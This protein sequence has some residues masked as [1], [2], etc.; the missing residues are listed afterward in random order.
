M[1]D[2]EFWF[3]QHYRPNAR[4]FYMYS[5]S[6]SFLEPAISRSVSKFSFESKAIVGYS[7]KLP[8]LNYIP[9]FKL[10]EL[11]RTKVK[12]SKILL[13]S[14]CCLIY[15]ESIILKIQKYRI[16]LN[17]NDL[18]TKGRNTDRA[19]IAP[20]QNIICPINLCSKQT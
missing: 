16:F 14:V 12:N 2:E 10:N 8:Q 7:V 19:M 9:R 17:R 5:C 3:E 4:A 11:F 1:S 18:I 15:P 20:E 13:N 6:L